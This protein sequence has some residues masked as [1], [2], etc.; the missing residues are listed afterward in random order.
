[1]HMM[2]SACNL[3]SYELWKKYASR[4]QATPPIHLRDLMDFKALG[5]RGTV[6]RGRKHHCDPQAV[7]YAG[8]EPGER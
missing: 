8:Y 2:Q 6:G 1:M 7:C 5:G 4:M 3:A